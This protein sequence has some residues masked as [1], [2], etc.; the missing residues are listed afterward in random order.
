MNSIVIVFV[1]T[2][3]RPPDLEWARRLPLTSAGQADEGGE[4][5]NPVDPAELTDGDRA[6]LWTWFIPN[7]RDR[8]G[9]FNE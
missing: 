4:F 6:P 3:G 9:P 5:P 8:R 2:G 7:P 1:P